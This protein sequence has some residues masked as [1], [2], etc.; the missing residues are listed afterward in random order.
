MITIEIVSRNVFDKVI[1]NLNPLRNYFINKM[2]TDLVNGLDGVKLLNR[3]IPF[4]SPTKLNTVPLFC[5][6]LLSRKEGKS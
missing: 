4:N 5:I 6:S 2:N 3:F 1:L